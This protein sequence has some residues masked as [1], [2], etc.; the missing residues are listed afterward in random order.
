L[1]TPWFSSTGIFAKKTE[2]TQDKTKTFYHLIPSTASNRNHDT[3]THK[4]VNT[5]SDTRQLV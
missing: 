1:F 2:S 3:H 4:Y 5:Q